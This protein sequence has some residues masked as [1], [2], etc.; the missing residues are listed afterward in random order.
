MAHC[1]ALAKEVPKMSELVSCFYIVET[2]KS[3]LLQLFSCHLT[4]SVNVAR[5][6]LP[7]P[8]RHTREAEATGR[9]SFAHNVNLT[10]TFFQMIHRIKIHQTNVWAMNQ[11]ERY[12]IFYIVCLHVYK[13]CSAL[14]H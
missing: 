14:L 7:L 8:S 3:T 11:I 2:V 1:A 5:K 9:S 13:L 10:T 6:E 4:R 12:Y